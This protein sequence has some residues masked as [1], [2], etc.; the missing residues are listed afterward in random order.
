MA[1]PNADHRIESVGGA[2]GIVFRSDIPRIV[3]RGPDNGPFVIADRRS[4]MVGKKV[5]DLYVGVVAVI[6]RLGCGPGELHQRHACPGLQHVV[7]QF[8]LRIA[9]GSRVALDAHQ[10]LAIPSEIP[11]TDLLTQCVECIRRQAPAQRVI[12]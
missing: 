11:R 12:S 8:R 3:E 10:V 4:A 2:F 1:H 6:Q 5:A 7:N 9:V